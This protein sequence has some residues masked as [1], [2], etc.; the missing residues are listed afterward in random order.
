MILGTEERGVEKCMLLDFCFVLTNGGTIVVEKE[1]RACET[2]RSG[3]L[4]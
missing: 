3:A 4:A 2:G 1:A